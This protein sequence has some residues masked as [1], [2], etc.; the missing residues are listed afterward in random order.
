MILQG[1]WEGEMQGTRFLRTVGPVCV[2]PI[3]RI[4]GRLESIF[5][6]HCVETPVSKCILGP[7][8]GLQFRV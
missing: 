7:R 1:F 3:F 4:F 5:G 6:P 2:V 8:V